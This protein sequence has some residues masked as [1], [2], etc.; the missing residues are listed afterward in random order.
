VLLQLGI[1]D[2]QLLCVERTRAAADTGADTTLRLN[3]ALAIAL[4]RVAYP[5]GLD[6]EDLGDFLRCPTGGRQHDRLDAVGLALVLRF[7]VC[8]MQLGEH[9]R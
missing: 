7:A 3:A 6:L 5:V 4:E 8:R 2:C 1:Q 9:I